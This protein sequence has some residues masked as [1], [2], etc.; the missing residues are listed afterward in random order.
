MKA[1]IALTE[2]F[3]AHGGELKNLYLTSEALRLARIEA[4]RVPGWDLSPRQLE[5][6]ELLSNGAFSPL[7]GFL[8]AED[9]ARVVTESR[10]A[11]G[12]LW[13]IPVVLDVSQV[14][15]AT[16]NVGERIALRDP[17]GAPLALLEIE[18]IYR[19]N[20]DA[21]ALAVYGTTD[22]HHPGVAAL[23]LRGNPVYLGGRVLGLEAPR[24]FD[25]RA[26]RQTPAELRRWFASKGWRRIVA[27]QTRNPIHR[28]HFELT[29]RAAE[30]VDAKL[31]LHP[32]VGQTKPGDIDHFTRVRAYR[33]VLPHYPNGSAQL[34]LLPLAMRM[35]GPREALWHALIRKN[36]GATH[37]IIGRD[38]AGPGSDRSGKPWYAPLAAQELVLGHQHEIGIEV[39]P[40]PALVYAAN[41]GTY[42]AANEARP[43]DEI[44]DISGTELRQ[45][46]ETGAEIPEWFT[47][48]GVERVLR[49]RHPVSRP[50]GAV[51]FFTGL[52]GAG[53]STLAQALIARLLESSS[54]P[55]TLLDG[56]L[57]R[58]HLSKGLGFSRQD[59][60]ANV[61]RIG[62]VASEIARHGGIAVA[63]PI[64]PFASARAEVRRLVEAAGEF[65]EVHV[66]TPLAVCEARDRKGLY[67]RA[68]SGELKQF[69]GIS[70][71]YEVPEAPEIRIEAEGADPY[72]QIDAV[73][74]LLRRRLVLD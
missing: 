40:F 39:V 55:V 5:D 45:R 31:L 38:H 51:V 4:S 65:I 28:A 68:R 53:K 19:P 66:S 52:S 33:E 29:R 34:S 18:S 41:R 30:S 26:L 14:F 15:A 50:R 6:L 67:A 21:E 25:F 27:F 37:F 23:L 58:K 13:P 74:E 63:A 47:F 10:L 56:D 22:T 71:P 8:G 64:A 73:L 32:V 1:S 44:R 49:E 24:H 54:R 7:A 12:T 16:L 35:A 70:D 59:R 42:I 48:P 72:V 36:Y 20:R 3:P 60:D 57:V 46:L 62:F 69:T 43:A 9:Y 17:E 2:N 61:T 11:D